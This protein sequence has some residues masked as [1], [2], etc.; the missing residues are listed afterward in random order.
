MKKLLGIVALLSL[1]VLAA[2]GDDDTTVICRVTYMGVDT[3]TT[4]YV[5]DGY[6]V[7]SVTEAVEYVGDDFTEDEVDFIRSISDDGVEFE[8]DGSYLVISYTIDFAEHGEAIPIDEAIADIEDQ[9]EGF[10]CD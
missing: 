8:L 10:V 5:E 4:I 6:A 3:E 1:F 7:R 2:C 9:P